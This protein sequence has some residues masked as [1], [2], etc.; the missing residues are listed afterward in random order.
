MKKDNKTLSATK[1]FNKLP[2]NR[3][4]EEAVL[5]MLMLESHAINAVSDILAKEIFFYEE[6][7]I[8]F[9][10]IKSI[11]DEGKAPDMMLVYAK[12]VKSGNLDDIGGAFYLT[13]MVSKVSSSVNLVEHSLYLRQLYIARSLII[14]GNKI[15]G[16]AYDE[17]L[18]VEDTLYEGLKLLES[19]SGEMTNGANTADLRILSLRSME[20][21]RERRENLLDGK[22]TGI[23]TGLEKLDNTLCGL[24]GG[25]LIILAARPAMGKT[26]FALNM[27]MSAAKAGK[28]TVIFSLEMSGTSL[29][30][31][32]LISQGDLSATAFRA[33]MLAGKDEENLC[34]AVNDLSSLQI[35]IDDTSGLSISQIKSIA[36]NLQRKGKCDFIIIDYLQLIDIRSENKNYSREQ[37]VAK[38]TK[39][40]KQLAK[41]MNVPIVLLSQLSRKCEERT[42]KTPI[43][44]DLRESGSIEQDSD[45]VLMLHRPEYYD[46]NQEQGAGI[47]RVAKQRD[48]KTGDIKFKYNRSL[49]KFSDYDTQCPY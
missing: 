26:A 45:V 23:L 38:C 43:L 19:I 4:I 46:K 8:V 36:K 11:S 40:I 47:I 35:T 41:K 17:S 39:E 44:S 2:G 34:N 7:A 37:E 24:K 21:Y 5:G 14:A 33:G 29:T 3:E 30:D 13:Q 10:A 48:G 6:N 16:M 22:K 49:T 27:A 20:L 28:K 9:E 32:M 31:R 25:Q 18:D 15:M 12:L 1:S 42:D